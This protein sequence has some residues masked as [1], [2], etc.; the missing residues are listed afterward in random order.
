MQLPLKIF[1]TPRGKTITCNWCGSAFMHTGRAQRQF[2]K[3]NFKDP[4]RCPLCREAVKAA[5][6]ARFMGKKARAQ[7]QAPKQPA[8]KH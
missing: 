7:A 3:E 8:A 2:K 6:K 5:K 1:G 4:V